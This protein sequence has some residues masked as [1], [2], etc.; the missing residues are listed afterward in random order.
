M[1]LPRRSIFFIIPLMLALCAF[2]AGAKAQ[3]CDAGLLE[4]N[5]LAASPL[6]KGARLFAAGNF[7]TAIVSGQEDVSDLVYVK[8]LA[9]E[10]R[11]RQVLSVLL[12]A[13]NG[14]FTEPLV[15]AEGAP[16]VSAGDSPSL[17]G[18]GPLDGDSHQD[19]AV[20]D[21]HIDEFNRRPKLRIFY[22]DGLGHFSTRSGVSVVSLDE[23][24]TP[25]AMAMGRFRGEEMPVDLAIVS[26]PKPGS[27]MRGTLKILFNNGGGEFIGAGGQPPTL[28]LG[29]LE[30]AA[31]VA[32]NRFR[33]VG[34]YDLAIKETV[35]STGRKRILYLQNAGN[36]HFPDISVLEDA[37][38][39]DFLATG[40][41]Q[42]ND[43]AGAKL[44]LITYNED[45]SL[46]IFVN[47]GFGGF[48]RRPFNPAD[49]A[50]KF[51]GSR[52]IFSADF[53]DR[54][55]RLITLATRERDE[56]QGVLLLTAD[57]SGRFLDP[58]FRI[59]PSIPGPPLGPANEQPVMASEAEGISTQPP[60]KSL[61]VFTG[62]QAP[63]FNERFGNPKGGLAFV[64]QGT[65]SETQLG[66]CPSDTS[67][68]PLA[69][70]QSHPVIGPIEMG[71]VCRNQGL[72]CLDGIAFCDDPPTD[73]R[74]FCSC[75]DPC[76]GAQPPPVACR[77]IKES[78]RFLVV[79]NS[80]AR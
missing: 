10:G 42:A 75:I 17:I 69:S 19:I 3:T 11:D 74:C 33:D 67:D 9:I 15:P 80:S 37:G 21:T 78:P 54:Q 41:L 70:C 73:G 20:I 50:F 13:G 6:G 55:L 60:K 43:T 29:D 18:V 44:D 45:L 32:S 31:I 56:R 12:S 39:V 52:Q 61:L 40:V 77:F 46:R 63:F 26:I 51:T 57:R 72:L 65:E 71:Q 34:K 76:E 8:T 30:P 4:M 16:A 7:H 68:P 22:G 25:V 1:T 62:V 2:A 64:A 24:E 5:G 53:G 35:R 59:F 14:C 49:G 28:S 66:R 23:G 58:E 48:N 36:G 47:D 27:P 79:V 38:D